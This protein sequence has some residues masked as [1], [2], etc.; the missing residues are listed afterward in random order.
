MKLYTRTG[1]CGET[2]LIGGG[3]VGK[4]DLRVATYGEVDELNAVLGFAVVA[5]AAGQG[6]E[7]ASW[8][9]RLQAIQDRLF[10]LGAELAT[11]A[12]AR[13]VAAV[14]DWHISDLESWIDEAD[15]R[16]SPLK[17]FVLPGG[18]EFAARLHLARTVCRRAERGVVAL[19]RGGADVTMPLKYLNRLSDLLFIWAR[20]ANVK[21]GVSDIVW[22]APSRSGKR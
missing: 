13:T 21:A 1:D 6:C 15:G 8:C 11:P 9:E 16:V 12:D 10:V 7:Q 4:D 20:L 3:R 2:G 5:G 19:H 22:T 14:E 17:Q 18:C